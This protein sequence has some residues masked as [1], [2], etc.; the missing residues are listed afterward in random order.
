MHLKLIRKSLINNVDIECYKTLPLTGQETIGWLIGQEIWWE[1]LKSSPVFPVELLANFKNPQINSD[2]LSGP[3]LTRPLHDLLLDN[4]EDIILCMQSG[5]LA[6]LPAIKVQNIVVIES[7]VPF[8]DEYLYAE[9]IKIR[10]VGLKR[11]LEF[12]CSSGITQ[13][14]SKLGKPIVPLYPEWMVPYGPLSMTLSPNGKTL[15]LN[16]GICLRTVDILRDESRD[17]SAIETAQ[18]VCGT[19]S[20][21]PNMELNCFAF[22]LD[23][24]YLILNFSDSKKRKNIF[25]ILR[26]NTVLKTIEN[27]GIAIQIIPITKEVFIWLDDCGQVR[28]ANI[29][30]KNEN[31][32]QELQEQ[33]Q[34][35]HFC[36]GVPGITASSD[37]KQLVCYESLSSTI[38]LFDVD[39]QKKTEIQLPRCRMYKASFSAGNENIIFLVEAYQMPKEYA[40]SSDNHYKFMCVYDIQSQ[41]I[42]S[43]FPLRTKSARVFDEKDFCI[44]DQG[45]AVNS[46]RGIDIFGLR[47]GERINTIQIKD[48]KDM[49]IDEKQ[50]K[51]LFLSFSSELLVHRF[52]EIKSRLQQTTAQLC[53][54]LSAPALF[55]DTEHHMQVQKEN[56][57]AKIKGIIHNEEHTQ[58]SSLLLSMPDEI[59]LRISNFFSAN[60]LST[61]APT[62]KQINRLTKDKVL[63]HF[64]YSKVMS[65]TS[66]F[67]NAKIEVAPGSYPPSIVNV[68]MSVDGRK[69]AVVERMKE[70]SR[71]NTEIDEFKDGWHE[72]DDDFERATY[73]IKLINNAGVIE[74]IVPVQQY[75]R[76][77]V[78]S[79]DNTCIMW[80][81][82]N[83]ELADINVLMVWSR[84]KNKIIRKINHHFD[85]FDF[86][87]RKS[88][89]YGQIIPLQDEKC[90]LMGRGQCGNNAN[91]AMVDMLHGQ[92]IPHLKTEKPLQYYVPLVCSW[93]ETQLAG[94]CT[95]IPFSTEYRIKFKGDRDEFNKQVNQ[96]Y[97]DPVIVLFDIKSGEK[98]EE[99][100][101]AQL[102][103]LQRKNSIKHI[104]FVENNTDLIVCG[105]LYLE[106]VERERLNALSESTTKKHTLHVYVYDLEEGKSKRNFQIEVNSSKCKIWSFKQGIVIRDINAAGEKEI[107]FFDPYRGECINTIANDSH[108]F[109]F[110]SSHGRVFFCNTKN[111][112]VYEFDR[113][114]LN[115]EMNP[116]PEPARLKMG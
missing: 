111:I 3:Y 4:T 64:D 96:G 9:M 6:R 85:Q 115:F 99:I 48:C 32:F 67:D 33:L 36:P 58:D 69:L 27:V 28:V 52:Y 21:L 82:K 78:F 90:I 2:D 10:A 37:G 20:Y 101:V 34:S 79:K 13:K 100:T 74:N 75:P 51:I 42:K 114:A 45:I 109:L 50:G 29:R 49:V 14:I 83:T 5:V 26:E 72:A 7:F 17:S 11:S 40:D 80:N 53:R 73:R 31:S 112:S 91:F 60:E 81:A 92:L 97:T 61:M 70:T 93:N 18:K 116:K 56:D 19:F 63:L 59:I 12:D 35:L 71:T 84:T 113:M 103:L 1:S 38:S 89:S 98:I 23:G 86:S 106:K 108:T 22:S 102:P 68:V 25:A 77:L 62:C 94:Y 30:K 66:I 39:S 55:F 88:T 54:S 105:E 65:T 41:K 43:F 110:D 95:L 16:Y 76:D 107:K 104:S 87:W 24:E 15:L 8:L 44:F 47:T 57:S 46:G